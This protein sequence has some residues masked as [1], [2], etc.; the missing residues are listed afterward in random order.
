M[1][2]FNFYRWK[3]M[4][5]VIMFIA[6]CNSAPTD[7]E[8]EN[9]RLV[10]TEWSESAGLTNLAKILLEEEMGYKVEL[11]LTEVAEAYSEIANQQADFFVDAWL[12]ETH[13][14]YIDAHAGKIDMIG[15]TFPD[16]RTGFVVPEYSRLK[17]IADLRD[18]NHPIIGIDE[19][20]GVMMNARKAIERNN[21]Q[22]PLLVL[23]EEEM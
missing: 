19:G 20:A 22:T 6:S 10:Y 13:K 16:A 12:P 23:S 18:Y 1:N 11:K 8:S 21:L 4:F 2:N 3:I 7:D 14:A 9:I 17:S 5:A 15:I